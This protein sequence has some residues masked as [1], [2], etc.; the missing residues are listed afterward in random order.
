MNILNDILTPTDVTLYRLDLPTGH[1]PS[2]QK[3]TMAVI[4]VQ[5]EKFTKTKDD[6]DCRID[7]GTRGRDLVLQV[8]A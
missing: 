6:W 4:P 1:K 3:G 2:V 5:N 8:S 7:P